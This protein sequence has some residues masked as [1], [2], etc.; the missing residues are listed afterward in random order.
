MEQEAG[1][2]VNDT[3]LGAA[4]EGAI[5]VVRIDA[6]VGDV[7][8]FIVRND[9]HVAVHEYQCVGGELLNFSIF[10]DGEGGA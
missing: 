2:T 7:N 4:K 1:A 10:I 5:A 6:E 3:T 8:L 9:M